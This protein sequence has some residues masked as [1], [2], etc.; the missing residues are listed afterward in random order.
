[1]R[2]FKKGMLRAVYLI[3]LWTLTGWFGCSNVLFK[4]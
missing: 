1:M 2:L 3:R 4:S